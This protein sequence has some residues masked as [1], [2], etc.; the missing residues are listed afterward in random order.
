MKGRGASGRG[1]EDEPVRNFP[2]FEVVVGEANESSDEKDGAENEE[3]CSVGADRT[4]GE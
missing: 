2:C 4:H 3:R 1:R